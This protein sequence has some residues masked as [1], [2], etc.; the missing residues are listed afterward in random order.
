[1]TATDTIPVTVENWRTGPQEVQGRL[2]VPGIAITP[3]SNTSDRF[4]L[5]HI[6]SGKAFLHSR[7]AEHIEVAA[8]AVRE[9][10][11]IDWTLPADQVTKVESV[12][13]LAQSIT[14]DGT[15]D[16]CYPCRDEVDPA[17]VWSVRCR[18]CGWED[19]GMAG[20]TSAKAARDLADDHTCEPDVEIE[21]PKLAAVSA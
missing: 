5:T 7:C 18:T 9:A 4:V 17:T 19:D 21:A 1:M 15:R 6:P 11:D 13:L 2:V 20:P 14:R 8:Q 16:G 3:Y 12:A 10:T